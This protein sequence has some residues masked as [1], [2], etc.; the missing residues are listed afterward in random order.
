[1]KSFANG[2]LKVENVGLF[3]VRSRRRTP[4]FSILNYATFRANAIRPGYF[5]F[6]IF[7]FQLF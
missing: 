2:K 4:P 6:S 5:Q 3:I 7:N 1:V